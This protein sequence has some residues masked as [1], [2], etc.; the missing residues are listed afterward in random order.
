[1]V[2][3][4]NRLKRE[5]M[6]NTALKLEGVETDQIRMLGR[7]PLHL[8]VIIEDMR[9][10]GFEFELQAPSVMTQL[11]DGV[12]HEPWEKV[13]LEFTDAM[14]GPVLNML[15]Q[16]HAE[17]GDT[18]QLSNERTVIECLLPV[19]SMMNLP[20]E[21]NRMTQG[22]GVLNHSAEG[23]R[24]AAA[25]VTE[26]ENG[27]LVAQETGD[28]TSYALSGLAKHGRFFVAPGDDVYYGQI[29]GENLG[30]KFQDIPVNV[31]KRNEQQGG[32]RANANDSAS[33]RKGV[34]SSVTMGLEDA[35]SWVHP[36]ELITVTPKSVRIRKPNFN[37]KTSNRLRAK[38]NMM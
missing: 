2:E 10:E 28:V 24:P 32:M 3:I 29:I 6:V 9:R 23:F 15:M 35:M 26:R 8:G 18:R 38:E 1:M 20:L 34:A 4:R 16:R 30:V 19:R 12:K 7:G 5:A 37:G 14:T 27:A 22:D 11:I 31:T 21:F 33:K 36:A 17:I 25:I 13:T